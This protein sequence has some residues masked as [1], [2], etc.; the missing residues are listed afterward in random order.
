[1]KRFLP[2]LLILISSLLSVS[3]SSAQSIQ[4]VQPLP[5]SGKT[6]PSTTAYVAGS[7]IDAATGLPL[8]GATIALNGKAVGATDTAGQFRVSLEVSGAY[9]MTDITITAPNYAA[10]TMQAT[11][12][13]ANVTRQLDPI[14]L[15]SNAITVRDGVIPGSVQRTPADYAAIQQLEAGIKHKQQREDT[16]N[17]EIP[18][19]I[20]VGITGYVHCSDWVNAGMPI[21]EVLTL[22][23]KDYAGNVLPNEWVS[24]W[25]PASLQAGAMA[26]KSY[27]WYRINLTDPRP[28]G[29]DV[30]DNT[31]DQYFVLNSHRDT[32]DAAIDATWHYR[33]SRENQIIDIHYL[34]YDYQ[35]EDLGWDMCMGQHESE[36][37]AEAGWTWQEILHFYYDPIDI[38]VTNTIAPNVNI[39]TNSS[40][41][42]DL[43]FWFPWGGIEN[44]AVVDG[45]F[46]FNRKVGSTNPATLYQDLNVRVPAETPMKVNLLLG[47]SSDVEKVVTVHLHDSDNWENAISCE[48]TLYPGLPMQKY[49]MYGSNPTAWVGMRVEITGETDD[50]LPSYLVDKVKAMYKPGGQPFD[51]PA[52]DAPRPGKPVII[53]P[54][55]GS[56]YGKNVLVK[57]TPG[58]SNERPGYDPAYQ[59]QVSTDSTFEDLVFDN[60]DE[61]SDTPQLTVVLP[62][63]DY[64]LRA[65]QFDG[66][67]RYSRWAKP[68]AFHVVV[69]PGIPV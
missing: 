42:D 8:A 64:Y 9:L 52:C 14:R 18:L 31:C 65:R 2:L 57:L 4:P 56:T 15:G 25:L 49:I 6:A 50:G 40:F 23:F 41:D 36:D 47:N 46:Q 67:D 59:V 55:A 34:A 11:A 53:T 30:V 10:W 16:S 12:L 26:V 22:D 35:C 38:N 69:M 27:A 29:A 21:E 19:T 61:L 24:D 33:M 28:E 39:V 37:K 5:Q 62:D 51:V 45:V 58:E 66:V 32:T 13:Q 3:L 48:F 17:I 54:V 1:M 44:Y 43:Y 20:K 68:V 63:G 60:V 7:V